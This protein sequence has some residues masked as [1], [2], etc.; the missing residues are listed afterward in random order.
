MRIAVIGAGNG[1]QATAGYLAMMGHSIYLYD[2]DK[3]KIDNL[4]LMGSITLSGAIQGSG[5]VEYLSNKMANEISTVEIIIVSTVATAHRAVAES[6]APYIRSGQ[7][8]I[9]TPGRTCGTLLFKSVLDSCGCKSNYYLA[10][11]QTLVFACRA[12]GCGN[13]NIIGVKDAV[14]MASLP[15]INTDRVLEILKPLFPQLVKADSVLQIGLENIGAVLH[16]SISLFNAAT[17]ERHN[18]FWFYRDL[19]SQVAQFIEQFDAERLLVGRAYGI[20]LISLFDWIKYAYHDTEGDTL[21]ERIR[22][23]PAYYDI[24]APGTIFARQLTEDIPTGVL[25]ILELGRAASLPMPLFESMMKIIEALLGQD[26]YN[27][28]SRTLKSLGLDGMS[29]NQIKEH[30]G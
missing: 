9:L 5:S 26:R 1:G 15:A 11:T 6:L 3:E 2:N 25:P 17:M 13:V 19:T 16:P 28:N 21:L 14:M 12:R 20:K 22:N 24:K 4:A 27:G 7:I 8:I 10:E 23:N 30:I 18:D 29:V